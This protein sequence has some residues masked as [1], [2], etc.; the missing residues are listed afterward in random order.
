MGQ[1]WALESSWAQLVLFSGTVGLGCARMGEVPSRRGST[2]G[3]LAGQTER[4]MAW[5]GA[6]V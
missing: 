5:W 6:G 3:S 2:E 1:G 4:H